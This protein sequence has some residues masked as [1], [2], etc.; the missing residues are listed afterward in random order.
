MFNFIP[1]V[2]GFVFFFFLSA[3]IGDDAKD[4]ESELFFYVACCADLT[5]EEF[6]SKD[7]AAASEKAQ[8]GREGKGQR[9]SRLDRT[10]RKC[11]FVDD[12]DF[13]RHHDF[14]DFGFFESLRE[15]DVDLLC[16]VGV[17]L[18]ADVALLGFR[19]TRNGFVVLRLKAGNGVIFSVRYGDSS[20]VCKFVREKFLLDGVAGWRLLGDDGCDFFFQVRLGFRDLLV[21]FLHLRMLIGIFPGVACLGRLELNETGLVLLDG[22]AVCDGRAGAGKLSIDAGEGGLGGLEVE[23]VLGFRL[24]QVGNLV[25]EAFHL[26]VSGVNLV[27]DL[28]SF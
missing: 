15:H 2:C 18:D 8:D 3:G 5:V 4:W 26:V 1:E 14:G 17:S 24:I 25:C 27:G 16:D 6:T 12:L 23:L 19:Q 22:G 13:V 21:D 28:V 9:F 7:E 20:F 10:L 11:G